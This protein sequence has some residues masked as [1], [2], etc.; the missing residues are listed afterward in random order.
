MPAPLLNKTTTFNAV[1]RCNEVV[2]AMKD[3]IR[4]YDD[5]LATL[6]HT[7]EAEANLSWAITELAGMLAGLYQLVDHMADTAARLHAEQALTS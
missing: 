3:D 5:H 6:V 1:K 2:Q 7:V 4:Y